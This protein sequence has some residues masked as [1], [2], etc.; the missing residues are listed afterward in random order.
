M[1]LI[2]I[3][4]VLTIVCLL[5]F[6]GGCPKSSGNASKDEIPPAGLAGT[7][8]RAGSINTDHPPQT[9]EQNALAQ[10]KLN[11]PIITGKIVEAIYKES[12][13]YVRLEV[14]S[15]ADT[16][17]AIV[18][19]KPTIGQVIKVQEQAVLKDFHSKSLDRTFDKITFGSIVD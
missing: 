3:K 10:A 8:E 12:F 5:S 4:S 11:R 1:R 17:V 13:A 14:G 9:A 6:V 19:Q 16:W 2:E 15:N 7:G 18:N